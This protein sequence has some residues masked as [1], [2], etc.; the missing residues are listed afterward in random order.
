MRKG[1]GFAGARVLRQHQ[2]DGVGGIDAALLLQFINPTGYGLNHIA[3]GLRGR[4]YLRRGLLLSHSL[5]LLYD[6]DSFLF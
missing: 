2:F 5:V 1:L 3:R 4:V 6:F